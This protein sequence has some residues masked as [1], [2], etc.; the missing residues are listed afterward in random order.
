MTFQEFKASVEQWAQDRG[1]Y[2]H[3]TALAQ[4]LKAVS[5]LGE[6][7]DHAIK[8]DRDAI[9]DD[10]GD[11]AV[12]LVNVAK[13]KGLT[14]VMEDPGENVM[15]EDLQECVAVMADVIGRIAS[16][17]ATYNPKEYAS[18]QFEGAFYALQDLAERAG[19][20]FEECY[21]HAWNEIKDR[22]GRMIPG[23]AFV[24]A[25]EAMNKNTSGP[26]FPVPLNPGESYQGHGPYDGMSLRD[27]FAAKAMQSIV[28][29]MSRTQY[30]YIGAEP[31]ASDAYAFADAML[32]E[33]EK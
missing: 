25:G 13:M 26:A 9:K 23:G 20:T 11:I 12:C 24:K 7:A 14:V 22:K 30:D 29:K 8:G 1:I 18:G 15:P 16:G 4:C 5:E 10:I 27:Y 33:R 6:L 32:K 21:T 3:S 17:L 19:F 28:S 31:V 2:E